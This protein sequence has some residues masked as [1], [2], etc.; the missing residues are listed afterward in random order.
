MK[1]CYTVNVVV[2]RKPA[3]LQC[4]EQVM[5]ELLFVS[6][7]VEKIP[8]FPSIKVCW[9]GSLGNLSFVTAFCQ[10][11][12]CQIFVWLPRCAWTNKETT[13]KIDCECASWGKT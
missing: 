6:R 7:K 8:K 3:A 11:E 5:T 4:E 10:K 12:H 13:R 9:T 2:S 1:T